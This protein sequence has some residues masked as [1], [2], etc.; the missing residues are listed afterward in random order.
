VASDH[1]EDDNPIEEILL[2][3]F[4]NPDRAGCPPP[5]VIEALGNGRIGREHEAWNHVWSCSPCFRDFKTIRD[6]RWASE[7]KQQQLKKV[8]W[9]GSWLGASAA[10]AVIL[11][12]FL[13]PTRRVVSVVTVSLVNSPTLRGNV[14]TNSVLATLP[15]RVDEVHLTLKPTS[16]SGNYIVAIL[17][18]MTERTAIAIG[19]GTTRIVDG[20]L[21]VVVV[22]DLSAAKPGKYYLATR[23]QRQG[24]DEDA[25][26]YPVLVKL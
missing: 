18:S 23:E 3:G 11:G 14:D 16:T 2:T 6:A 4:P 5:D 12:S 24:V 19:S 15:R 1:I 9:R 20:H 7:K 26:Y 10:C 8:I 25:Y 13:L 21:E 17:P 22:L